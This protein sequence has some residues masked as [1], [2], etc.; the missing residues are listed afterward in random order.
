MANNE[1][2]DVR[3]AIGR[4]AQ[5]RIGRELRLM[6]R[7]T[8][9]EP[10]P[11]D[12]AALLLAFEHAETARNNLAQVVQTFREANPQPRRSKGGAPSLRATG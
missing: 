4:L 6:Y 7:R 10:L 1:L 12:F 8:L 2:P 11:D 5:D 3:P 9:Q